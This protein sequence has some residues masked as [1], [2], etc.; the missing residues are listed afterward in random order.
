M[1]RKKQYETKKYFDGIE[2][3]A[4][5]LALLGLTD[6]QMADVWEVSIKTL[7]YWKAKRTEF[8]KALRE[9]RD[10]AN[11]KV[12][13]SLYQRAVGYSHPET[14]YFRVGKGKKAHIKAI[15]TIRH[16]PP[17]ANAA[18]KILGI[19]QR[20]QWA[21]IQQVEHSINANFQITHLTQQIKDPNHFSNSEL[22]AAL[23]LGIHK[24][25]ILE[26]QTN[27]N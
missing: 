12:V 11:A 3:Q 10:L 22:K 20:Q 24:Q 15:Q 26:N 27:N 8:R 2:K 16:Y 13:D 23:K 7:E 6:R 5:Q 19:R 1:T 14:K 25:M 21:D 17:D 4:Y 9:G 18:L